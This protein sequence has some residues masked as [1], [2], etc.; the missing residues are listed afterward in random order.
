VE[1]TGGRR[2]EGRVAVIAGG[3]SGLGL[4]IARGFAR[5][6][7]RVV[8]AARSGERLNAAARDVDALPIECDIT[9]FESVEALA[10]ETLERCGRI[11]VA[12]NSAG[13]EQQTAIRDITPE[14]LEPM[15]AVQFTGAVYFMRH[16]ANAMRSGGSLV[17]VSSLT[18]V[19]VPQNYAAYAGAKAGINHVTRIAASE[20]GAEGIRVNAVAPSVVETPMTAHLLAIPAVQSAFLEQ[21][22]LAR[23]GEPEDVTAAVLWLASDEASY[24]TG[25]VLVIDGGTSTRKLPSNED[26]ARHL[27]NAS[28]DS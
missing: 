17:T 11:D 22:P 26:V 2:F 5:E 7:A 9:R 19:L 25:Q 6:G 10:S 18:G 27:K 20:Y 23:M 4:Q 12:V 1:R 8:I 28:A 24:I 14:T 3:S 16:M 13:F 21:T 15:V